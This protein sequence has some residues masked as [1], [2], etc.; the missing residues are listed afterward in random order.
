MSEKKRSAW[1]T[2]SAC[3]GSLAAL[4]AGGIPIYH[5]YMKLQESEPR[6]IVQGKPTMYPDSTHIALTSKSN[7]AT[8]ILRVTFRPEAEQGPRV[9][10]GL[11]QF[12]K[13]P[14]EAIWVTFTL[15]D[16]DE[17]K[18]EFRKQLEE[19]IPAKSH[20]T[21]CVTIVDPIRAGEQR[22]GL[23]TIEYGDAESPKAVQLSDV[24][25]DLAKGSPS[26]NP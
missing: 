18:S 6:L 9:P 21:L 4:V 8:R 3:I 17:Q 22:V 11:E 16:W 1:K 7:E 10:P 26:R 13:A 19:Q 20:A 15:R 12:V 25:I 2:L 14:I 23:L 5:Q 24:C